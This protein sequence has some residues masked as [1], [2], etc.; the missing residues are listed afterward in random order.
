V[1]V[2]AL[3]EALVEADSLS[4]VEA[5]L[6]DFEQANSDSRRW[7]PVG[8][9][10]N[11]RGTIDSAADPGRSL[12]ERLTNGIDAVLEYQ[13]DAHNGM[14]DCRTPKEAA[15]CWLNVAANGLSDMTPRQ[16]RALAQEVSIKVL[17]GESRASRIV[18]IRDGG[19]GLT[20]DDM[21]R[22]IL[23]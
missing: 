5:A 20:P 3:Y 4:T 1:N 7:L 6:H 18:E 22:T 12:V 13:H 9:R 10:E 2:T 8:G 21:P 19:I 17:A 11:N 14:P 23:S 16:R 15:A